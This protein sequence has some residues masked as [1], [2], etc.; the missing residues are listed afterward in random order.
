MVKFLSFGSSFGGFAMPVDFPGLTPQPIL[1]GDVLVALTDIFD[2]KNER[3]HGRILQYTHDFELKG[4]LMTGK[5][6][7]TTGLAFAPDG[8]LFAMDQ[9]ARAVTRFD[10]QGRKLPDIAFGDKKPFGCVVFAKDGSVLMGEHFIG[11]ASEY[12][13]GD[14]DLYRF[15]LDGKQLNMWDVEVDGGIA[16]FLGLTHM[17]LASDQRTL[18]Y[19]S[20][21]GPRIM[22]FDIVAGKQLPDLVNFKGQEPRRMF[23]AVKYLPDDTLLVG[24]GNGA[25]RLDQSGNVIREYKMPHG[26]GWSVITVAPDGKHFYFGDFFAGEFARIA[27]DSGEVEKIVAT[28]KKKALAGV[29]EAPPLPA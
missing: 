21:T 6:G 28:E 7:L 4:A 14:G 16:N 18:A 22:R 24:V 17:T 25:Q 10:R 9:H 15:S 3:G 27:V 19:V 2:E 5:E 26:R 13:Y 1:P 11:R 20:E 12:W 23:F 8:T 29:I